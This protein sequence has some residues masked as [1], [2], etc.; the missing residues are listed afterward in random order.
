MSAKVN[1]DVISKNFNMKQVLFLF[2]LLLPQQ[3]LNGTN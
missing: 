1:D 3:R 2:L